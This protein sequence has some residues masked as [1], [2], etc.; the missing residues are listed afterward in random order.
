MA[1]KMRL[2]RSGAKKRPFYRIVVADS[3][4]PRDGR[5]IEKIGTY[6]PV[7]DPEELVIEEEKALEWLAKGAQPS[8]TVRNLLSSQGIMQK[9]HESKQAK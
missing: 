8:D 5:I 7:A 9:F 3:R 6:N 2:R 4:S 1:V